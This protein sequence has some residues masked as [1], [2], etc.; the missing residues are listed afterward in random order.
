MTKLMNQ[1]QEYMEKMIALLL[2]IFPIGLLL[3]EA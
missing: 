2:L 3:G 1:K